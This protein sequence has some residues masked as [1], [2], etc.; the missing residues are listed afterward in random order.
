[1][2]SV[3]G[4][5]G[6]QTTRR[7]PILFSI[8]SASGHLL[9]MESG[10]LPLNSSGLW[11]M[12]LPG[13][14]PGGAFNDGVTNWF[15]SWV[16]EYPTAGPFWATL[17]TDYTPP[18]DLP[19]GPLMAVVIQLGSTDPIEG[20]EW[21]SG[22]E[23]YFEDD[24]NDPTG[25]EPVDGA[26]VSTNLPTLR[27]NLTASNF[28]ALVRGEWQLA[29]DAGFT[30][31]VRTITEPLAD[32]RLSG[33]TSEVVPDASAL[34]TGTWYVRGRAKN[35][36]GAVSGWIGPNDFTVAHLPT[37]SGH[38]PRAGAASAYGAGEVSM[39]WAFGSPSP[40]LAEAGQTAYQVIVQEL[41][42]TPVGDTGKVSSPLGGTT[43]T[44][45]DAGLKGDTLRWKVRVWDA[46][47]VVGN[48]SDWQLFTVVDAP[49][50]TVDAPTGTVDNP[51]PEAEWTYTPAEG[52][53]QVRYRVD[54]YETDPAAPLF[55]SGWVLGAATS[56]A[57]PST[58][59]LAN[60]AEYTVRVR[61]QDALG[62]EGSDTETFATE[63]EPP[64]APT[65]TVEAS[66][67]DRLGPV[68]ILVDTDGGDT[69]DANFAGW[70]V[71][72]RLASDPDTVEQ[73]GSD[74]FRSDVFIRAT[75]YRARPHVSNEYAVVQLANR[76]G[77]VVE[78]DRV[79]HAVTPSARAFWLIVDEEHA[80]DGPTEDDVEPEMLAASSSLRYVQVEGD[81][82]A[83]R[84]ERVEYG[85]IDRGNKVELGTDF[86]TA[87]TLEIH[88]TDTDAEAAYEQELA[89]EALLTETVTLRKPSGAVFEANVY[90]VSST[91]Q[92]RDDWVIVSVPYTAVTD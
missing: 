44:S 45:L 4:P 19:L 5:S 24:P 52:G 86:G 66:V 26:T 60:M 3:T 40:D 1:M 77:V 12:G 30:T 34:A 63:W 14:L 25:L 80:I 73:V 39:R 88:L 11:G 48:Y 32:H 46:E 56:Y 37:T 15:P 29:T 58:A 68:T 23:F 38:S 78:S 87:G 50:V 90:D 7:P 35:D 57:I 67:Y 79:W 17:G 43:I 75:H 89:L 61:V 20:A 64:D 81:A 10:E 16:W 6:A 47:D 13:G 59:G 9:V 18:V 53:G 65:V 33:V 69:Y 82:H 85:I 54:V 83:P 21:A 92:G 70:R 91:P 42:G 76:F 31:N 51:G 27:L 55:D 22:P 49:T 84:L 2:P 74:Y 8:A 36:A 62:L 28:E 72:W 71:L 41:D